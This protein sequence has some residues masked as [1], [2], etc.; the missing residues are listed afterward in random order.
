MA[1]PLDGVAVQAQAQEVVRQAVLRQIAL[2]GQ[3]AQML[4]LLLA[5][6]ARIEHRHKHHQR[7]HLQAGRWAGVHFV[8][9]LGAQHVVRRKQSE[10]A[11]G[12]LHAF[13][14]AASEAL[15]EQ[16]LRWRIS[17]NG[18]DTFLL[19]RFMCRQSANV[20]VLTPGTG[21]PYTLCI[22]ITANFGR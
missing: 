19:A 17:T 12:R 11:G 14:F 13:Y 2:A 5:R 18:A 16:K 9:Q 7:G 4:P 20:G 10:G 15:A 1:L 6:D 21:P 8:V 22:A 3:L